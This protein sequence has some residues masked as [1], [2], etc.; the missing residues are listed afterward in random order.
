MHR[1]VGRVL[2]PVERFA[3]IE[4]AS[5]ILLVVATA[6]ALLW[7]NS[8]W[9]DA[10]ER[11]WA[12]EVSVGI[13]AHTVARS[14]AWVVNDILMAVFFFVVGMEIRSEMASGAL[15][16]LRK[17][18]LPL[19]AAIGGMVVPAL[20][21]V[22]MTHD[23]PTLGRGW[24]VPMAT[25]IA[26][27]LGVLALLGPRVPA[28][29]RV[30]LLAVAVID[31][32]GA[33]VVIAAFYS[34]GVELTGLG[35]AGLGIVAILVLQLAGVRLRGVYVVPA[36]AVWV[37][38]YVGGLHPT[39]AGVVVGLLTPV[40][41]W[42]GRRELVEAVG[43]NV[44]A[45][46]PD[47]PVTPASLRELRQAQREATSPAADLIDALHPWVAFVIMPLFAL[48]NAGVDLRAV[49]F[50]DTTMLTVGA[51]AGGL[52]IGKPLGV[53]LGVALVVRAGVAT[54]PPQVPARAVLVLGLVAGIGFTMSLFIATLA[55]GDAASLDAARLGVLVASGVAAV[56]AWIAGRILLHAPA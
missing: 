33:I 38:A 25:D 40:T 2:A 8:P 44:A 23:A 26:F 21:F 27:A 19:A 37:G 32:L 16:S 30:T 46:E 6:V 47:E 28:S 11:L 35:I 12:T 48:A 14:L 10:L 51:I 34:D 7:A 42:F 50:D 22:A 39:I 9:S 24:G 1:A 45:P 4:S 54:L 20:I 13:G 43:R 56:A 31:D 18:T 53:C 5:G 36:L 52:V 55:F 29:L 15:D 41:A 17:A 49:T 3:Q